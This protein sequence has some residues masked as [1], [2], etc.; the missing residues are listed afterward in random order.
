ML[1][2][3]IKTPTQ[4]RRE[5]IPLKSYNAYFYGGFYLY[6]QIMTFCFSASSR[7]RVRKAFDFCPISLQAIGD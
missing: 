6:F 4:R 2:F 3:K 7:L 5:K 1:E